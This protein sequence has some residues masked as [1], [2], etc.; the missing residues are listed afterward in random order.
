[1]PPRTDRQPWN[2]Q[3]EWPLTFDYWRLM[4]FDAGGKALILY[5]GGTEEEAESATQLPIRVDD[6]VVGFL[7]YVPRLQRVESLESITREQ[8]ADRIQVIGLGTFAAVL[9]IA[10]MV[11][12]WL[13]R[14]LSVLGAGATALA[15]GDYATRIP[16]RGH[17]ELARLA[18]DFNHL[19]EALEAAQRGRQQWIADIAHELR[20][21]LTALRAE[22]EAVQDG[23]RPLTSA[24]IASV[25]QEVQ[26]LTRLVEDL[27]LLTLSDLGA[28]TY[29]KEPLDLDE[30]ISDALAAGRAALEQKPLD[31][32]LRL[33]PGIIVD[34]D[35]DRLAQV[36]GNLLQNT[37]RYTAAPASL[38]I[39][40][41]AEGREARIDWEDSA[42]GVGD[43]DLGRLT[44]RLYRVDASRS[45]SSGGSGL[46]LAI[47]Q[48]IVHAHG[49]RMQAGHSS[50]GGLRWRIWLPLSDHA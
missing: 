16:V 35:P 13:S 7:G 11:A 42:P 31:L 38:D 8:Q 26:R 40:L 33:E 41:T 21:P 1:M 12:H 18:G 25:A 44:E 20:T 46:G 28:L 14:R 45:S 47:V 19:A 22:I 9:I 32:K 24:S 27:R 30:V 4:L 49:G 37:L 17:D 15:R 29:R 2:F 48:A 3:D 34:A 36:F 43:E 23:V 5:P 6:R 10:W 39:G 50:L